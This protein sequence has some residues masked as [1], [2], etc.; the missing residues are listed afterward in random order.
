MFKS[1]GK[2]W[3]MASNYGIEN[4]MPFSEQKSI[5]IL[6]QYSIVGMLIA[7]FYSILLLIISAHDLVI[8]DVNI[9]VVLIFVFLITKRFGYK[10]GSVFLFI[11]TPPSLG[12]LNLIYGEVGGHYYFFPIFILAFY[13]YGKNYKLIL[14]ALYLIFLFALSVWLEDKS[15]PSENAQKFVY[16]FLH[17]NLLFSFFMSFLFL[18]LFILEHERNQLEISRQNQLLEKSIRDAERKNIEIENLLKE[19]S[20]RTKNNL[21]IISSIMNIQSSKITDENAKQAIAENRNRIT[22]ILILHQKLYSD[23]T[24]SKVNIKD[25]LWDLI[26]HLKTAFIER[27]ELKIEVDAEDFFI[28]INLA[29]SLGLVINELL[30]NSFKH[31]AINKDENFIKIESLKLDSNNISIKV[32]DSGTGIEKMKLDYYETGFGKKLIYTLIKQMDGE[33][34]IGENNENSVKIII[35]LLE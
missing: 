13:I 10:T 5:R 9:L 22:S 6:N 32:K 24:L 16:Y 15:N 7:S 26:N 8:Y 14:L 1:I 21:Q 31:G 28:Q 4:S 30:T 34:F 2:I 35:P 27:N 20:H 29:T 3:N 12:I 33:I 25:Y 18:R 19:L 17:I 23:S 11:F